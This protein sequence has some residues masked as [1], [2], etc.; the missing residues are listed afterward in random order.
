MEPALLGVGA[1]LGCL[2]GDSG[3]G[4]EGRLSC[5]DCGL[6]VRAP[7]PRDWENLGIEGASGVRLEAPKSGLPRNEAVVKSDFPR[8]EALKFG[9]SR[10][11]A[12][13]LL[14]YEGVVGV[15]GRSEADIARFFARWM[16]R[17]MPEPGTEVWK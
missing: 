17:N 14:P 11:D 7:G 1:R 6:V 4:S 3:R 16:G 13:N 5:L 10:V 9:L 2:Y 12:L 15:G 8:V